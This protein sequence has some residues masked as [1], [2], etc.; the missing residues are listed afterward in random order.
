MEYP[1]FQ[2]TEEEGLSNSILQIATGEER[3]QNERRIAAAGD[4]LIPIDVGHMAGRPVDR[5]WCMTDCISDSVEKR[6]WCTPRSL[7]RRRVQ[8]LS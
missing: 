5:D 6:R 2:S 3:D 8:I 1:G 4:T 7:C